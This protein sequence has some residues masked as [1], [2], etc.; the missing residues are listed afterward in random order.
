LYEEER[1]RI[2][3]KTNLGTKR[4]CES[5]ESRFYDLGR[6]P[7]VCP[8]CST[9]F[10]EAKPA[11]KPKKPVEKKPEVKDEA[12]TKEVTTAPE[13]ETE[14]DED[15]GA[16]LVSLEDA[17]QE[18]GASDDDA[19]DDVAADG[20]DIDVSDIAPDGDDDDDDAEDDTFLED[21]EDDDPNV[22]DLVGGAGSD[23][24]A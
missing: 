19:D 17:D 22:T 9:T 3:A 21:D 18:R 15:D 10:V 2:V 12:E 5:C 6:T 23:D 8:K 13:S 1:D 4:L 16:E 7:I 24:E 14:D 11:P 20:D